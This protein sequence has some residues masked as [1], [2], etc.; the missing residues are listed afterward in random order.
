MIILTNNLIMKKNLRFTLLSFLLFLGF[1]SVSWGQY[2]GAGTF[3]KIT[4]LAE[5]TDGYY[6]ITNNT[7]AFA[8]S[9]QHTGTLLPPVGVTA[10]SN[11]ITN[12]PTTLV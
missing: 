12:P 5:L 6:V 1:S 9:N 7:D 11:S 2:L 4:S 10:S 8:M 3:T